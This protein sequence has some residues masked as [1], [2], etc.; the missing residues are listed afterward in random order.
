MIAA[1]CQILENWFTKQCSY[2]PEADFASGNSNL[3]EFHPNTDSDTAT[4][5]SYVSAAGRS[6]PQNY[7]IVQQ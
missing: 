3:Q 2:N 6:D 5:N 7:R 1:V 4:K